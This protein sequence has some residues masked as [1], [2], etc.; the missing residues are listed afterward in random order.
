MPFR[1]FST[2]LILFIQITG[3]VMMLL[4]LWCFTFTSSVV[5]SCRLCG[6]CLFRLGLGLSTTRRWCHCSNHRCPKLVLDTW[7]RL[8]LLQAFNRHQVAFCLKPRPEH[9]LPFP[10]NLANKTPTP[11]ILAAMSCHLGRWGTVT[12][13]VGTAEWDAYWGCLNMVLRPR[14]GRGHARVGTLPRALHPA[15]WT[16]GTR[17]QAGRAC[18]TSID[19]DGAWLRRKI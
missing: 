1:D 6:L 14:A 19:I 17:D 3:P 18:P 11:A 12:N 7:T 16:G 9:V 5:C 4:P 2:L 10:P 13:L 8:Y 15:F